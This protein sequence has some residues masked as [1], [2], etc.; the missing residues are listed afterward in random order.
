MAVPL[1]DPRMET[2]LTYSASP[3]PGPLTTSTPASQHP[4]SALKNVAM[5]SVPVEDDLRRRP[6]PELGKQVEN[7]LSEQNINFPPQGMSNLDL[8]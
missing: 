3:P 7:C 1:G 5:I 8:L 6:E 2:G 4:V